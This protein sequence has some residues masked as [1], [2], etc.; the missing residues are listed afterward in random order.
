MRAAW[1]ALALTLAGCGKKVEPADAAR[2]FFDLIASGKAA[3]AYA[4]ATFGF[5]GQQ[6]LRFFETTLRELGL[7]AIASVKY[8]SPT[9]AHERRVARVE[10]E[11]MTKSKEKVPL[12][13]ALIQLDGKWRVFSLK[14]PRDRYTGL[15]ENRFTLVGRDPGFL[16]PT[17]RQPPPAEA[18]VKTLTNES[19]L[20]FNDAI[21]RK[22]FLDLFEQCSLRWQDQLVTRDAPAAIPGTMRRAL[23]EKQKE[24]GAARLLHAFQSFVD[25]QID[26][27]GIKGIEP[28]FDRPAWVNTEGLLVVS[29]Y[30]PTRPYRVLFSLKFTYELPVWRL[31][32]LDVGLKKIDGEKS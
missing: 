12:V 25:Q 16:D 28:V 17:D 15:I 26:I 29:G 23:T 6:T 1:F 13:I 14:S 4:S 27:S 8:S 11:F 18:V 30:Y 2:N 31:F 24:L 9:F 5:Q 32:G 22:S 21:Q 10:A 7:D 20:A 3:Q 19:L